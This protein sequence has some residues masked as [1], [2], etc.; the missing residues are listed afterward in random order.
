MSG[1]ISRNQ[2]CP[3]PDSGMNPRSCIVNAAFSKPRLSGRT[4]YLLPA[5]VD[6]NLDGLSWLTYHDKSMRRS[7]LWLF[8]L[9]VS[10]CVTLTPAGG[11]ISI[12]YA[13]LDGP[14]AR[15]AMPDG[16]QR[17][18]VSPKGW[19]SERDIE[20][21]AH[22]FASQQ[23]ASAVE[24][25]N[26]LLVLK[27]QVRSRRDPECPSASPI[28]DCPGSSGAWYDVVFESYTCTPEAIRTLNTPKSEGR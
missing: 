23:N 6:K 27:K 16:C 21:Q 4:F 17:L 8:A 22:P 25:G 12:Y 14:P 2:H 18:T 19:M 26:V 10:G 5:S 20:G 24:G 28:R 15:R 7:A 3:L 1:R 9:L 13:P 11:R